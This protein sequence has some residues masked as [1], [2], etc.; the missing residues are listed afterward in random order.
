MADR[1]A[2]ALVHA[3]SGDITKRGPAEKMLK[4][5]EQRNFPM[6]LQQLCAQVQ[7]PKLPIPARQ[8]AG[9]QLKN[10]IVARDEQRR[11]E[12]EKRWL[13]LQQ[14][15]RGN[16]KMQLLHTLNVDEEKLRNIAA[17]VVA[18]V[19]AIEIPRNQWRGLVPQLLSAIAEKK[20]K[21]QLKEACFTT[22]GYVCEE[23]PEQLQNHSNQI[24]NA[25]ATGMSKEQSNGKIKL[26]ATRALANTLPMVKKNF[27]VPKERQL[28]MQMIFSASQSPDPRVRLACMQCLEEV[29]R[30]YYKYM[31]RD[32][33]NIF[34]LT[35]E[36]IKK[37][38]EDIAKQAI[39]FW[40]TVCEEEIDIQLDAKELEG[41]RQPKQMFGFV[42]TAAP[43]LIPLLLMCLTKQ[44]EDPED[45]TWNVAEAAAC[46]LQRIAQNI[47]DAVV[48]LVLPFVTKKIKDPNWRLRDAATIAFACILDGPTKQK[49]NG[50]V[51]Q[52]FGVILQHMEDSQQH[53]K[54][55]AAWTIGKICD[56]LPETISADILPRLMNALGRGLS[57]TPK[58]ANHV[59]WAIHNLAKE[60]KIVNGTSALSKYFPKMV[61]Q[62]LATASRGDA[63]HTL[64]HSA[65]EAMNQMIY[66]A[67]PDTYPFIARLV[68]ELLSRLR[69]TL[70]VQGNLSQHQL[71]R[72]GNAQ[73]QLC[74]ALSFSI[75]KNPQQNQ[76]YMN[77]LMEFLIRVLRQPNSV[78]HEEALMC[79]SAVA[80]CT[81]QRFIN[82]MKVL[83]PFVM[84]HLRDTSSYKICS[85]A[86]GLVGDITRAL[87][88]KIAPFCN[89]IVE[90]LMRNFRVLT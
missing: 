45:E 55:S 18:K 73:A 47:E 53:V 43:K 51:K 23:C 81:G 46:C 62:L 61:E 4:E 86:T 89:E 34:T 42:K 69:K 80:R 84:R 36:A 77:H 70:Q 14:Q 63:D 12:L 44:S 29:A 20:T 40:T 26:E 38:G 15:I 32:I 31:S 60:V 37:E 25:I 16:I 10:T 65:F 13:L 11:H 78:A 59:C 21:D 9:I 39:E 30:S 74:A 41:K 79:I 19:A 67:A 90:E 35:S 57:Q 8:L 72:I 75:V 68:P 1:L 27:N 28:I 33:G 5:F 50:L 56:D 22:L 3:V 48:P 87:E 7:N 24:L 49:L 52:A 71:T 83:Q 85:I 17:Q 76:Q 88:I 58:V 6:Y 2:E 64:Q 66:N 54:D 82:Y